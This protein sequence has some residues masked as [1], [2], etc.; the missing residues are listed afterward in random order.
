MLEAS[1]FN[2]ENTSDNFKSLDIIDLNKTDHNHHS[3]DSCQDQ[4]IPKKSIRSGGAGVLFL[5]FQ[6]LSSVNLI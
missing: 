4:G 2:P 3:Y 6:I 5:N 1:N